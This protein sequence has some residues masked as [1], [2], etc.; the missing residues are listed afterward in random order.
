MGIYAEQCDH[1]NPVENLQHHPWDLEL[2]IT[3]KESIAEKKGKS[4]FP[5]CYSEKI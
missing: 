5:D 2:Y 3:N 4:D 1:S